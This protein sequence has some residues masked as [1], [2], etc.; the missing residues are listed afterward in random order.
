MSGRKPIKKVGV[1]F[2]FFICPPVFFFNVSYFVFLSFWGFYQHEFK[3]AIEYS[4]EQIHVETFY[5]QLIKNEINI[6]TGGTKTPQSISEE[7][8]GGGGAALGGFVFNG[9]GDQLEL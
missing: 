1:L 5:Q 8:G 7:I 3:S 4:F 9:V 6:S 2:L